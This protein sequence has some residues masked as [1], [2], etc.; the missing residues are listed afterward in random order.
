MVSTEPIETI[1]TRALTKKTET[2]EQYLLAQ[3]DLDEISGI[4]SIGKFFRPSNMT[5]SSFAALLATKMDK[6]SFENPCK[7]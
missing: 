1:L 7:F 5:F 3:N 4:P 2:N 6:I